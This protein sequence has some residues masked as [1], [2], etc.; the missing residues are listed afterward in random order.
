[1]RSTYGFLVISG[2][3]SDFFD[4]AAAALRYA[5]FYASLGW[6]S[7]FYRAFLDHSGHVQVCG[8]LSEDVLRRLV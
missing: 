7:L 6:D 3:A 1:M 4:D 8:R 5:E 2:D